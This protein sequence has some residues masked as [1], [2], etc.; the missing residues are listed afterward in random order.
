MESLDNK[1]FSRVFSVEGDPGTREETKVVMK[2]PPNKT[3]LDWGLLKISKPGRNSRTE[4]KSSPAE[5]FLIDNPFV[6]E[7]RRH[8][9]N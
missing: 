1:P 8:R 6:L 9:F 3:L 5:S 4:G 2:A 7:V